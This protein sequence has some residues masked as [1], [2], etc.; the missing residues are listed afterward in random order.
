MSIVRCEYCQRNVDLDA[1]CDHFTNEEL[2]ECVEMPEKLESKDSIIAKMI[3]EMPYV[4]NSSII[5]YIKEAMGIH[6]MNVSK[7][8]R[9][10]LDS[11]VKEALKYKVKYKMAVE[12]SNRLKKQHDEMLEALQ[13]IL[14]SLGHYKDMHISVQKKYLAAENAI[15]KATE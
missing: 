5:P 12:G 10:H 8:A 14:P 3:D 9:K 2:T 6:A 7:M 4:V 15:K 1:D 11:S 13:N